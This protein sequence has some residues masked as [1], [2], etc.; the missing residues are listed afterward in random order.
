MKV[1]KSHIP[2]K[3]TLIWKSQLFFK[4]DKSP[5]W[6]Y[7]SKYISFWENGCIFKGLRNSKGKG[8][9]LKTSSMLLRSMYHF[10]FIWKWDID[11]LFATATWVDDA[12]NLGINDHDLHGKLFTLFLHVHLYVKVLSN[13][14]SKCKAC[15]YCNVGL[16]ILLIHTCASFS[17]CLGIL[18]FMYWRLIAF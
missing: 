10:H 2:F 15:A 9:S 16:N 4:R 13:L 6:G 18:V 3:I 17:V 14:S 8:S 1:W 11:L 7:F 12:I 5:E